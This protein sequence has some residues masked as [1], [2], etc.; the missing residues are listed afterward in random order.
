[1]R[2]HHTPWF[3]LQRMGLPPMLCEQANLIFLVD[4]VDALRTC[5]HGVDESAL[6][7]EKIAS[8][9]GGLFSPDLVEIFLS[10]SDNE[11]FWFSLDDE[12]LEL[13][14][15]EW[16]HQRPP[17]IMEFGALLELARMFAGIVDGKSRFTYRHSLGVCAVATLLANLSH[18]EEAER[19]TVVLASLLHDLGKLK[20]EDAI[21][22][23]PG[24]FDASE[25]KA[26]NHHSFDTEQI[27]K[28]IGGFGEIARIASLHHETLDGT[29]YP[30]R[31]K[32]EAIP[33]AAR[34]IAVAD[35]FQA[36]VQDRPYRQPLTLDAAC[37]VMTQMVVRGKLDPEV[38]GVLFAHGK[39]AYALARQHEVGES[40]DFLD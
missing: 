17:E 9:S 20:V 24:P 4:R 30:R 23:K 13:F 18:L 31:I 19:E 10:A 32:G 37:E 29:G 15:Q 6:W 11:S 7:R 25:R 39:E 35:I 12:P 5:S 14:Y 8:H 2:Y 33:K 3:Q 26:M 40:G 38:V 21:L 36:L 22:D 27:L 34:I 1:V 16:V 28:R